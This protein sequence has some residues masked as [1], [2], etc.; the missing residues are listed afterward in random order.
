MITE[1]TKEF[2]AA[3][4]PTGR[5]LGIDLGTKRIGI[6]ISDTL[7]TIA[8]P[9]EMIE[10]IKFSHVCASVRKICDDEKILGIVI[11]LPKNINGTE[12]KMSQSVKQFA[13]NMHKEIALPTLLWDERWSS[14]M[15]EKALIEANVSRQNRV[16]KVDKVAASY[17]L[18]G[19]LD[20]L[21]N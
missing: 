4:K 11:G 8:T 6:A 18:Q 14:V 10:N 1:N 12:S 7:Q 21:K 19:A 9:K 17:I 13:R 15:A 5:L 2:K 20:A 3:I 16:N